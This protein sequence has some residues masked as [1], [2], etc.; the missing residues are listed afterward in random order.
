MNTVLK[1]EPQLIVIP[2]MPSPKLRSTSYFNMGNTQ[3]VG[4]CKGQ[5]QHAFGEIIKRNQS[6]VSAMLY[7]L[8]PDWA[9][10]TED[11]SQEVFIR[12]WRSINQLQ[13]PARLRSWVYR[14]VM[15]LFYDELRKRSR[16]IPAS[17]LDESQYDE[18]SADNSGRDIAEKRPGPEELCINSQLQQVIYE[19]MSGLP[20]YF[21]EV[22]I[23]REVHGLAYHEIAA[24]TNAS[25]GTVKSRIARARRRIRENIAPFVDT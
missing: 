20:D 2:A 4:L 14:I 22:I 8:A 10:D 3:L 16:V 25:V 6:I 18:D 21:R 1:V 12:M 11:L 24:K 19:E 7:R 9:G 5:D 13:D 17:S 15:N 23:L